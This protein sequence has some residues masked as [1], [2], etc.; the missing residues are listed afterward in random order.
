MHSFFDEPP[1]ERMDY[2][3]AATVARAFYNQ[4]AVLQDTVELRSGKTIATRVGRWPMLLISLLALGAA[5]AASRRESEPG[6]ELQE[7]GD[8]AVV[9]EGDEHVGAEAPGLDADAE[10]T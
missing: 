9:L 7:D 3:A 5:W 2:R 4:A 1:L 6:S 8:G 10:L